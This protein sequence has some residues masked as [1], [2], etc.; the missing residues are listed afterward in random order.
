MHTERGSLS[1]AAA[2]TMGALIFVG[3]AA[4]GCSPIGTT[5]GHDKACFYTEAGQQAETDSQVALIRTA[6]ES[7]KEPSSAFAYRSTQNAFNVMK[8]KIRGFWG[9]MT[10]PA[11]EQEEK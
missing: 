9:N 2:L 10:A 4:I 5:A 11:I 6:K 3:L 1:F 8:A 7:R